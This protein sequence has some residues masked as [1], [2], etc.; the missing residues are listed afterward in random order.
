MK[1]SD[2]QLETPSK[3]FEFERISRELDNTDDTDLL[4]EI[5]KCNLKLYMKQ[6]EVIA[7]LGLP[8]SN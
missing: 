5:A 6:Q 4:R 3:M 8:E 1:S 2:I 7:K